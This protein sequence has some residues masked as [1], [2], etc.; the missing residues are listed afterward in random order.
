MEGH[1]VVGYGGSD[2]KP[3][4]MVTAFGDYPMAAKGVG[5][6]PIIVGTTNISGQVRLNTQSLDVEF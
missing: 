6:H 1:V 2:I 4:W 3:G 5:A